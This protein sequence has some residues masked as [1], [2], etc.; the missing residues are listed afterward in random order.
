MSHICICD[1]EEG[2]LKYFGKVLK[3]YQ[4][5]TFNRGEELLAHLESEAG[6]R[7]ELLLQDLR[8][9]DLD[10]IQILRRVKEM[11]PDLP[12]III[13]AYATI[14]DAVRAIK[15]GA[16][17]YV[18]KPC[19]NEKLLSMVEN[20]LHLSRLTAENR[21]LRARIHGGGHEPI[22]F[23]SPRFR[24]VYDLTLKVASSDANILILGESGTGK[25][26]I[27]SA[28]HHNSLRRHHP[29]VSLN[30]ASLSDT[31]LESQLFGHL[32]GAFTGAFANQKGMLEEADGG[33]LFL[34]EIGDISP[35]VQ[36]KLLRVIQERDF[37]P[38]G[39]THPKNVNV[40]FVAATNKELQ[41]EVS[42]G[43]FREDLYYRLNVITITLP[44]LRERPEDVE[45][46]ARHFLHRFSE[47]MG[48]EIHGIDSRALAALQAYTWP[49][50]VRELE[51]VME[52]AVILTSGSH[53][54]ADV[55]P[56]H[57]EQ[58]EPS[59]VPAPAHQ[60]QMV[61][62]DEMERQHIEAVLRGNHYNKSRTA[63][64]LGISRR[65]L[66]RRISDFGLMNWEE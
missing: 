46:L 49:G 14:D 7:V 51:N 29:F 33:T 43:H 5:A 13:T 47:C 17:D 8:M 48:K 30:C 3:K 16:Y 34:D 12:V 25:E 31:L 36:G 65:T 63:E 22:I 4:V 57:S 23:S 26:L 44:P 6:D 1:D 38:I 20:V 39:S 66:D 62:L 41:N 2:I 56:L 19:P 28:L 59:S 45:P 27:A 61:A 37:I 10:G 58:K 24:E 21:R 18:T 64:I 40:R 42:E 53:I 55:I 54:S 9:P 11:R 50:N 15:L 32:R 60:P 52:R 35:A